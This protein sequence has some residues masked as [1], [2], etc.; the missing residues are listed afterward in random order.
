MKL[1]YHHLV[2][3]AHHLKIY[4]DNHLSVWSATNLSA[5]HDLS[6]LF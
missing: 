1:L 5:L 4:V 2:A 6:A 3:D